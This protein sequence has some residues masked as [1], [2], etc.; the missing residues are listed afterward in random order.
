MRL[1]FN[2]L[3]GNLCNVTHT[4]ASILLVKKYLCQQNNPNHK[5]NVS[6]SCTMT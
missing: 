6:V 1:K 4:S 5:I 3:Q 2:T